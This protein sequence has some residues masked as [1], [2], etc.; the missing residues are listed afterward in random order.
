MELQGSKTCS[1]QHLSLSW[2]NVKEQLSCCM[3]HLHLWLAEAQRALLTFPHAEGWEH[4][5]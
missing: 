5:G 2:E 1:K 3:K 4:G